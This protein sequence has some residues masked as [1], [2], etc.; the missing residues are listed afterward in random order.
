M[1]MRLGFRMTWSQELESI[2]V[3]ITLYRSQTSL[4]LRG[5]MRISEIRGKH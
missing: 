2:G 1:G 3:I 4:P 5:V